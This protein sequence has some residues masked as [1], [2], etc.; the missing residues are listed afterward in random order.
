MGHH[1]T[2]ASLN[3][4]TTEADYAETGILETSSTAFVVG[5]TVLLV[6]LALFYA[7]TAVKGHVNTANTVEALFTGVDLSYLRGFIIQR[8]PP[9]VSGDD[10]AEG[11]RAIK[12]VQR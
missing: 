1:Y 2:A 4:P 5:V 7:A 12:F 10:S 6:G 3:G 11:G 9:S 8:P